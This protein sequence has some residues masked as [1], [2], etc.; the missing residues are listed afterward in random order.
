MVRLLMSSFITSGGHFEF[1]P[2]DPDPRL[3]RPEVSDINITIHM[4]THGCVSLCI[5]HQTDT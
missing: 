3:R 2:E 1:L 5:M 4:V